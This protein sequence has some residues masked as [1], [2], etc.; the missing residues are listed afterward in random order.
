MDPYELD[1]LAI[2]RIKQLMED[3]DLFEVSMRK[4]DSSSNSEYFQVSHK[5]VLS[6]FGLKFVGT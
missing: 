6:Y 3:G 1:L 5:K 2:Q 4:N